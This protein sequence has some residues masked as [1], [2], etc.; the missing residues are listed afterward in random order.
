MFFVLSL[1][2]VLVVT[3]LYLAG[4]RY[5]YRPNNDNR[6]LDKGDLVSLLLDQMEP[7][8]KRET[9][10]GYPA[11]RRLIIQHKLTQG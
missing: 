11:L 2:F 4:K 3:S 7:K 6:L 1:F 10:A 5:H 8:L 9:S